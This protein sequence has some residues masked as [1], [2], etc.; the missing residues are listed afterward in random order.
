MKFNLIWVTW[1]CKI[2][3]IMLVLYKRNIKDM[4]NFPQEDLLFRILLNEMT[5]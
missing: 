1:L 3:S 4:G 5:L 2:Y